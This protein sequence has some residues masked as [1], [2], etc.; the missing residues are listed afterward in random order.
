LPCNGPNDIFNPDGILFI[1]YFVTVYVTFIEDFTFLGSN[2]I[3]II[4]GTLINP[5]ILNGYLTGYK[6]D[7]ILIKLFTS[8]WT[9]AEM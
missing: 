8:R 5:N 7:R 9:R 6:M 2:F 3:R 4:R 1:L